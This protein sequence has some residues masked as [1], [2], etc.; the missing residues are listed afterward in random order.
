[1]ALTERLQLLIESVGGSAAVND[2]LRIGDAGERGYSKAS[3]SADDY[4][5]AVRRSHEKVAEASASGAAALAKANEKVESAQ[6]KAKQSAAEVERAQQRVAETAPGTLQAA[7]A[8]ESLESA[9][10]RASHAAAAL[11]RA[12]A[13]FQ[14][15]TARTNST[16]DEAKREL[17]AAEVAAA[18]F[19]VTTTAAGEKVQRLGVDAQETGTALKVALAATATAAGLALLKFAKDGVDSFL[20]L[21]GQV[22]SYQRVSGAL[23]EDAS[24]IV[25]AARTLKIEV[26]AVSTGVF[27]LSQVVEK[28]PEKLRSLGVEIALA[29]DGTVDLTATL[30]NVAEAYSRAGSQTDKNTIAVTAFGKGSR[31]L[32]PLLAQGKEGLDKLAEAAANRG[33]ILTEDDLRKAAEYKRA[34]SDLNLTIDGIRREI[35]SATLPVVTSF[36]RALESTVETAGK[37]FALIAAGSVAG[38]AGIVKITESVVTMREAVAGGTAAMGRLA[39]AAKGLAAVGVLAGVALGISAAIDQITKD[40]EKLNRAQRQL[41]TSTGREQLQALLR[42]AATTG[43]NFKEVVEDLAQTNLAAA[44]RLS[45]DL[46]RFGEGTAAEYEAIFK[47]VSTANRQAAED[48][49]AN[50]ETLQEAI[51]PMEQLSA[52]GDRLK[53]AYTLGALSAGALERANSGLSAE[54]ERQKGVYDQ[55]VGRIDDFTSAV[56]RSLGV[57]LDVEAADVRFQGAILDLNDALEKNGEIW[58]SNTREG[59]AN[60]EA[61]DRLVRSAG[62]L[63]SA[64]VR[65]GQVTATSTAQKEALIGKLRDLQ[66]AFPQ[67]TEVLDGYI[68]KVESVPDEKT[69]RFKVEGIEAGQV[70]LNVLRSIFD[71]PN[72]KTV[73][74]TYTQSGTGRE[75]GPGRSGIGVATGGVLTAAGV[76][77]FAS[78]GFMTTGPTFLVGEGRPEWEEYVIASDPQYRQRNIGLWLKAGQRLGLLAHGGVAGMGYP[79]SVGGVNNVTV[80]VQL[81]AANVVDIIEEGLARN[82]ARKGRLAFEYS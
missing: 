20:E 47:R 82:K 29:S 21:T 69:T 1:M 34:V 66:H 54:L 17:A 65:D 58:A 32:I 23:P 57:T 67:L 64:L 79:S 74:V 9:Q 24:K 46:V 16:V 18:R 4:A 28:T 3:K 40:T 35:G 76:R 31:E 78:G 41:D 62:D 11:E 45:E 27:K 61:L 43:K 10:L 33:D 63:V 38:V 77:S 19:G 49:E 42:V 68:R 56:E 8:S 51:G 6:L 36:T 13:N 26:D 71:L 59:Q 75:Y 25:A 60:R 73:N 22:R 30:R 5:A 12:Q 14:S 2:L 55:L 81:G 53:D 15:T 52:A 7:K 44:R 80:R 70:A 72:Q 50:T 48:Q 37:P 39:T